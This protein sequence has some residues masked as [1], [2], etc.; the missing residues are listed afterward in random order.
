MLLH[1]NI[2]HLILFLKKSTNVPNSSWSIQEISV[3]LRQ[4]THNFNIKT[5]AKYLLFC[6]SEHYL[7]KNETVNTL[8]FKVFLFWF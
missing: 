8:A 4:F 3:F 2:L 6:V 7:I 1:Q 5:F